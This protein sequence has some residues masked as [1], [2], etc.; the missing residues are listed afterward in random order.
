MTQYDLETSLRTEYIDD[1]SHCGHESIDDDDFCWSDRMTRVSFNELV[2]CK[3]TISRSEITAEEAL[4]CWYTSEERQKLTKKY[5]KT[6]ERKLAGKKPKK[7]SSYRGLETF[8]H[9]S[10]MELKRS[11]EACVDAV[12]LEQHRQWREGIHDWESYAKASM[13]HSEQSKKLAL[14]IAKADEREA[15]KAYRL[16]AMRPEDSSRSMSSTSVEPV[17]DFKQLVAHKTSQALIVL[18]ISN[19]QLIG[20]ISGV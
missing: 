9:C 6:V 13:E 16:L 18:P 1:C 15:K 19:K 7:N 10:A 4:A 12:L 3:A 11:I 5:V 2:T 17:Q 20:D 14:T 8:E